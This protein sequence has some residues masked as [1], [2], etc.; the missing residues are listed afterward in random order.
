MGGNVIVHLLSDTSLP[1]EFRKFFLRAS[2]F[3][4]K[5]AKKMQFGSLKSRSQSRSSAKLFLQ[6]SELGLPHPLTPRR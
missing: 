2:P 4:T 5:R 1:H 3:D 6:S